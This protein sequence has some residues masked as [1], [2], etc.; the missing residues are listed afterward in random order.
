MLKTA[1]AWAAAKFALAE[2]KANDDYY[3]DL[4]KFNFSGVTD[5]STY[6]KVVL[7]LAP[8]E[9]Q[10]KIERLYRDKFEDLSLSE[11]YQLLGLPETKTKYSP[12][13][14]KWAFEYFKKFGTFEYSD[15]NIVTSE[16][17][18]S[19]LSIKDAWEYEQL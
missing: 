17:L 8:P 9:E 7:D 18:L 4:A 11:I 15:K 6:N 2:Y 3:H 13:E 5:R 1:L 12:L 10:R 16:E 19:R 14:S